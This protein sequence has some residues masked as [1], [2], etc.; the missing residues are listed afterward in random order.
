ME[1]KCET[2]EGSQAGGQG[3]AK[4]G[5]VT[6][7]IKNNDIHGTTYVIKGSGLELLQP[8]REKR[9]GPVIQYGPLN[10][11]MPTPVPICGGQAL[12][13]RTKT[14]EGLES[15]GTAPPS[16]WEQSSGDGAPGRQHDTFTTTWDSGTPQQPGQ[17]GSSS[18]K[19]QLSSQSVRSVVT[20]P[21]PAPILATFS[22]ISSWLGQ[23]ASKNQQ[24]YQL[25]E[26]V[27][28]GR[29]KEDEL[30][31]FRNLVS[32]LQ[33]NL[34]SV[35]GRTV[36]YF[37]DEVR[38][39]LQIVLAS[40]PSQTSSTLHP[41]RDSDPLIVSL[42]RT[43][44]DDAVLREAIYRVAKGEAELTDATDLKNTLDRFHQTSEQ[45]LLGS[46][47][48]TRI[49]PQNETQMSKPQ[50]QS[51]TSEA[52][53]QPDSHASRVTEPPRRRQPQATAV[54]FDFGDNDHYLFP[55]FSLLEYQS[56]PSSQEVVASFLLVF[57]GK[58]D[59]SSEHNYYEQ[60]HIRLSASSEQLLD[61]LKQVVA[62]EDEV[63]R[64]MDNVTGTMKRAE[65]IVFAIGGRGDA[66][67]ERLFLSVRAIA[68]H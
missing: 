62:P 5:R 36:K 39:I 35:N 21:S 19:T 66:G 32:R 22:P 42:T 51:M 3:P 38:L 28:E 8:T 30:V 18:L 34:L 49:E 4:L 6:I 14:A 48:L 65:Y 41:P 23:E 17:T 20:R 29:A 56:A 26:N 44:L 27:F 64:Y 45:Q 2:L 53:C 63:R 61:Q 57:R 59:E 31:W 25:L 7:T 67:N 47:C 37:A 55:S 12:V 50:V 43:A 46:R 60:F 52:K 58:G 54:V 16:C 40:N 15:Y 13:E 68:A 10:G 24:L 9:P 33:A 1:R 11:S